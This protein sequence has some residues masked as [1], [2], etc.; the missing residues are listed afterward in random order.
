MFW[1]IETDDLSQTFGQDSFEI[2]YE[3]SESGDICHMTIRGLNDEQGEEFTEDNCKPPYMY[4][5]EDSE[6]R[7]LTVEDIPRLSEIIHGP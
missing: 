2:D 6:C 4:S 7:P 3:K 5:C 1:V